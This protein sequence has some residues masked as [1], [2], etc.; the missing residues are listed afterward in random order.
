MNERLVYNIARAKYLMRLFTT[1]KLKNAAMLQVHLDKHW[2]S[3]DYEAWNSLCEDE[4]QVWKDEAVSWLYSL[5]G[6]RP[7]Q[8]QILISNWKDID[9][10]R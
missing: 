3:S 2:P 1:A 9:H 5:Q 6:R 4:K 8:F 7:E 10:E